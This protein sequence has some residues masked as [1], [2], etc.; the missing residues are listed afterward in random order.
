MT[1]YYILYTDGEPEFN[2]RGRWIETESRE[3]VFEDLAKLELPGKAYLIDVCLTE[4][5]AGVLAD[6]ITKDFQFSQWVVNFG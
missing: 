1:R 4:S 3:T 6:S 5:E 2:V